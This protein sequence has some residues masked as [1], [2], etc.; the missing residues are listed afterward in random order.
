MPRIM[1]MVMALG[2]GALLTACSV[3]EPAQTEVPPVTRRPEATPPVYKRF[4]QRPRK[5]PLTRTQAAGGT[6]SDHSLSPLN[7]LPPVVRTRRIA[8][9]RRNLSWRA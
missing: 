5:S 7:H 6:P 3:E 2:L 9:R 8:P 1:L 4:R